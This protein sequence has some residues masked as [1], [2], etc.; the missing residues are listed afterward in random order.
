MDW[1]RLTKFKSVIF[2]QIANNVYKGSDNNGFLCYILRRPFPSL[3]GSTGY[4]VVPAAP[5]KNVLMSGSNE[6]S[7]DQDPEQKQLTTFE[8]FQEK[9]RECDVHG[10]ITY[11]K[12]KLP[13]N[14][15]DLLDKDIVVLGFDTSH[16][17]SPR[18]PSYEFMISEVLKLSKWAYNVLNNKDTDDREYPKPDQDLDKDFFSYTLRAL[19]VEGR[20]LPLPR[21]QGYNIETYIMEVF[22]R[23]KEGFSEDEE[24][25]E[26][27]KSYYREIEMEAVRKTASRFLKGMS[28][29]K[30]PKESGEESSE[31]SEEDSEDSAEKLSS[32]DTSDKVMSALMKMMM[33]MPSEDQ[34]D[35]N[36]DLDEDTDKEDQVDE[37]EDQ[38]DKESNIEPQYQLSDRDVELL[39]HNHILQE[40]NDEIERTGKPRQEIALRYGNES[41]EI[42]YNWIL[43][44]VPGGQEWV[45]QRRAENATRG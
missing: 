14:D 19:E 8:L 9:D 16:G 45:R 25:T 43:N 2:K 34:T 26:D 21:P 11:V 23:I 31:E 15:K 4:V 44:N 5:T 28:G 30:E 22:R 20:K 29:L 33:S 40:V 39:W 18:D 42:K 37:D 24:L 17:D 38:V 36:E 13:I 6:D 41:P 12:T 7:E 3:V 27:E 35:P 10:S 32:R 1:P